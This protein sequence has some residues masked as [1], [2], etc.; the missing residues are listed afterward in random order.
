MLMYLPIV[1][2]V[3]PE[4]NVFVY[5][6]SYNYKRAT[7]P[8]VDTSLCEV[9]KLSEL[10]IDIASR[11]CLNSENSATTR[12]NLQSDKRFLGIAAKYYL[13]TS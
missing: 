8:L 11:D 7:S 3:L 6:Y 10:I 5:S 2:G 9:R 12:P 4:I 13:F 1:Y